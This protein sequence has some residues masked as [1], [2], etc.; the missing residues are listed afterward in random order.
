LIKVVIPD[1][2]LEEWFMKSLLP[3]ISRDV[4]MGGVFTEEESIAKSH[5]LY[6]V[7][8][9]SGTLY[10]LIPNATHATNDPSKPSSSS[11]ADGVIGSVK[12]QSTSQSAGDAPRSASTSTPSPTTPS[13]SSHTQVSE[14]N[15]VQ[16]TPSQQTGGNKNTKNKNKKT[17]NNEQ[18][19]P[20][21]PPP[22]NENKP[23]RKP[24]FSCLIYGDDHYTQD[25]PHHDEVT[26]IFKGNSQP[27]VLTQP[28]P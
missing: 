8:S 16:S 22:T 6:L 25:C 10:E 7:Y 28:F 11:P 9:Q 3:W 18:P 19:K 26:K 12:T 27:V 1:Q 14:V 5:Y 20:Q 4:S 23:Q 15:A 13:T 21:K 2:L 17:K 24:N